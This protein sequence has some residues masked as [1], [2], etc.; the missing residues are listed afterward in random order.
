MSTVRNCCRCCRWFALMHINFPSIFHVEYSRVYTTTRAICSGT[1]IYTVIRR[2]NSML[3]RK[4]NIKYIKNE[5][6]QKS[7]I[8]KHDLARLHGNIVMVIECDTK[9]T[10]ARA[11]EIHGIWMQT[12]CCRALGIASHDRECMW[13]LLALFNVAYD[14]MYMNYYTNDWL[15]ATNKIHYERS[16]ICRN[17]IWTKLSP[18]RSQTN[19]KASQ[20]ANHRVCVCMC[21]CSI[22]TGW[23]AM[24]TQCTPPI[25]RILYLWY[26]HVTVCVQRTYNLLHFIKQMDAY[27]T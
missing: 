4:R 17:G 15:R 1:L 23:W 22:S 11:F 25:L 8:Y 12:G 19:A 18:N 10:C 7:I 20:R 16:Y 27:Y 24:A 13:A 5:P 21:V 14:M 2:T 6:T 9:F 3:E 26:A